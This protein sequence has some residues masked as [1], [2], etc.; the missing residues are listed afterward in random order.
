MRKILSIYIKIYMAYKDNRQKPKS[1]FGPCFP[2]YLGG[3]TS[4]VAF[5][6]LWSFT[7]MN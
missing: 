5:S 2:E 7:F 1:T 3:G 6:I 4:F